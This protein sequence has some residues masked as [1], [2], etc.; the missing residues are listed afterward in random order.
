MCE[1]RSTDR[2]GVDP[3]GA[4]CDRFEAELRAGKAPRIEAALARA[5]AAHRSELF[6]ELLAVEF[7]WR[8]FAGQ[9]P[10]AVDYQARFPDLAAVVEHC[11]RT[12]RKLLDPD[13]GSF[14]GH[15][16]VGHT[17]CWAEYRPVPGGFELINA[18]AHRMSLEGE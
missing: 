6:A 17:T 4:A 13:A 12:G 16:V 3:I 10:Q 18:Y 8:R 9:D 2:A 1:G 15:L 7:D 14:S 11:E 5:D